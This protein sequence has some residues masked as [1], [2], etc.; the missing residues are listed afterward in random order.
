MANDAFARLPAPFVGSGPNGQMTE[1]EARALLDELAL[2]GETLHDFAMARGFKSQRLSWWKSKFA[3]KHPPRAARRSSARAKRVVGTPR[4]VPVVV[5]KPSATRRV[6][7]TAAIVP[8][9]RA[10]YELAL[11]DTFTLRI[12][13][14]FHED[15]LARIVRVLRETR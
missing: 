11:G 3:G 14:D 15:S 13:H 9:G 7:P 5:A 8:S 4:F 1:S 2:S 10:A 12:P 6:A